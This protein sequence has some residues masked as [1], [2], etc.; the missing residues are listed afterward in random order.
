MIEKNCSMNVSHCLMQF[1]T[2]HRL[3]YSREKT[4][5]FLMF[6]PHATGANLQ[7]VLTVNSFFLAMQEIVDILEKH[8]S[9]LLFG[10]REMF[11]V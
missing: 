2:L 5:S 11:E 4:V 9:L 7:L 3:Y 1:K 8:F 6:H 10:L